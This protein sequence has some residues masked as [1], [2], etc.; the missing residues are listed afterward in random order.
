MHPIFKSRTKEI[1]L[2]V[3]LG[4]L[5]PNR[6]SSGLPQGRRWEKRTKKEA[7]GLI[8]RMDKQD[9]GKPERGG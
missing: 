8:P 7:C 5:D 9:Q 1:S 4:K 6:N 3:Q 2:P